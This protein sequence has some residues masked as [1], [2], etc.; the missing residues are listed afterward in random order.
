MEP[1]VEDPTIMTM[2]ATTYS[3]SVSYIE[4]TGMISPYPLLAIVQVAQ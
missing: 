2:R 4:I 3:G 1:Y